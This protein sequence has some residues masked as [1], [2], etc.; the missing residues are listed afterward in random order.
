MGR[1]ALFENTTAT[2]NTAVG[3]GA[4]QDATTGHE[5]TAVGF[6]VPETSLLEE[7]M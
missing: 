2:D 6:P 1:V 4:L 7:V 5:N 3:Y